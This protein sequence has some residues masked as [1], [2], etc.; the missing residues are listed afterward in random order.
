M[1]SRASVIQAFL[2]LYDEP[3]YLEIGVNRGETF[4]ILKA[5]RKVAVNPKFLFDAHA[6]ES[7]SSAEYYEVPSDEFFGTYHDGAKFDVI[8]VDGLH[9]FDQTLRDLL[10]SA[11]V[12]AERGVIIVDDV[13]PNSYDAS[14]RDFSQIAAL[15]TQTRELG[16]LWQTD[17][18][19]MGDVYKVPFFIDQFMQQ[20]SFATVAENHG[21]SV[22]WRQVRSSD[23]LTKADFDGIS[24]LDF[25]D[26]V[27]SRSRFRLRSLQE[28][29]LDVRRAYDLSDASPE[30]NQRTN[31]VPYPAE[32]LAATL[33][34]PG[35]ETPMPQ[36]SFPELMPD[37]VRAVQS[38]IW[39]AYRDD[40]TMSV[41]RLRDVYVVEEGLIFDEHGAVFAPSTVKFSEAAIHEAYC[42]L[43]AQLD[44][45]ALHRYYGPHLLCGQA[46]LSNYGHWLVEILPMAYVAREIIPQDDWRVFIPKVYP[47]MQAVVRDSLDLLGVHSSR[48]VE[49]AGGVAW[50][51]ELIVVSGMTEHGKFYLPVTAECLQIIASDVPADGSEKVW[52]SRLGEQRSFQYEAELNERLQASGWR[53]ILP[54]EMSLRQQ[55]AAC[56]GARF[57]AGVNGAGL[58]N[59]AFMPPGGR[60]TSFVPAHMPDLFFWALASN[61]ELAFHDVRCSTLPAED[62]TIAWD[63]KLTL[64]A[65]EVIHLI[66]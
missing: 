43:K 23:E 20:M 21:Q 49:G 59:M 18:S 64:T 3:R 63:V 30:F 16:L 4:H 9:T 36:V 57:M 53:V 15:R 33:H 52:V 29:V 19:W 7:S 41:H 58:T 13:I 14:L 60:V 1:I 56:A 39:G 10:N 65:D 35:G 54:R 26:T 66:G 24:R 37:S 31:L 44:H 55:I 62:T 25:R 28:I 8:F 42:G 22:V 32:T 51:E 6:R 50:F 45:A 11:M 38:K 48:C 17:G 27:L 12:L 46:G 40:R 5:G 34:A 2:N 61:A 47:W